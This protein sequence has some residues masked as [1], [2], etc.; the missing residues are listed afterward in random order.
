MANSHM[1]KC[2]ALLIIGEMQVQITSH[3]VEE[4]W[5]GSLQITYTREGVEE[6]NL[7]DLRRES[8]LV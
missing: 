6:G 8:N 2:S 5:S 4:P 1:E 3:Q 7:L